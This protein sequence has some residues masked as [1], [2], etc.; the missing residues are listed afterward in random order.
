M[1]LNMII[2]FIMIIVVLLL[3]IIRIIILIIVITTMIIQL[4]IRSGAPADEWPA[5]HQVEPA[6]CHAGLGKGQ[7]GS[8]LMGVAANLSL[9]VTIVD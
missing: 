9:I 4:M 7:M 5:A 6:E 8:A 2:I 3:L 1:I